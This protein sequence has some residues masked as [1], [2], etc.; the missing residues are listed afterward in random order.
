MVRGLGALDDAEVL[1]AEGDFKAAGWLMSLL[2]PSGMI[3]SDSEVLL[4][5]RW[6]LKVEVLGML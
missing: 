1:R 3:F 5:S 6:H 4:W 2:L